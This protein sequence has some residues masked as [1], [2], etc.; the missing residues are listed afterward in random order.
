MRNTGLLS[1][2]LKLCGLA[3]RLA[4]ATVFFSHPL[5]AAEEAP[6]ELIPNGNFGELDANG[7]IRF[8]S[9]KVNPKSFAEIDGVQALRLPPGTSL[10]W[11]MPGQVVWNTEY[12]LRFRVKS[13]GGERH[14]A[15]CLW[16]RLPDMHE[17]PPGGMINTKDWSTADAK[18][19]SWRETRYK[20]PFGV[21]RFIAFFNGIQPDGP[22]TYFTDFSLK[23]LNDHVVKLD[24]KGPS[25]GS[26]SREQLQ[27]IWYEPGFKWNSQAMGRDVGTALPKPEHV[28]FR[29]TLQFPK[30][31]TNVQAVFCGDDVAKLY[32]NR[33]EVAYT[34][35]ASDIARVSLDRLFQDGANEVSFDVTNRFGPG[36]MLGR[37]EW[38]LGNTKYYFPTNTNWE[39][40]SDDGVTWKTASIAALPTPLPSESRWVYPHMEELTQTYAINVPA[41]VGAIRAT[42]RATGG[43]HFSQEGRNLTP[44]LS[45]VGIPMQLEISDAHA[46]QPLELSLTDMCQPPVG[47]AALEWKIGDHWERHELGEFQEKSGA[48]P[49]V[50]Q[51]AYPSKSWP[52]NVGGFEAAAT[53]PLRDLSQNKED[54]AEKVFSKS[55]ELWSIGFDNR[56]VDEFGEVSKASKTANVP[57]ANLSQFPSGLFGK[58]FPE[59]TL[60][61]HL[62]KA[63]Q[64][65]AVFALNVYDASAIVTTVGVYLNGVYVGSPNV[66]GYSMKPGVRPGNRV[67]L[68]TIAPERFAAGD[69]ELTLRI[70][71]SYYHQ[72]NMARQNQA[73]EYTR[74]M[75]LGSLPPE[76]PASEWLRWDS[77]SLREMNEPI[78]TPINGR[79]AWFGTN[80]GIAVLRNAAIWNDYL[81]RDLGYLGMDY[82]EAPIRWGIWDKGQMRSMLKPLPGQAEGQ[83]GADLVLSEMNEKGMKPHMIL[84]PGRGCANWEDFEKSNEVEAVKRFGQYFDTI[85]TGNEVDHPNYGWDSLSISKAYGNI[86]KATA[87]GQALKKYSPNPRT[88]ILGQGWYFAW[89]FSVLDA[90]QRQAAPNDPGFADILSAHSYG[91]SYII[92]AVAYWNL[93]GPVPPKPIWVTECGAYT[94]SLTDI[95]DFDANLRG[96]LSFA[97]AVLEYRVHSSGMDVSGAHE[98]SFCLFEGESPEA[99]LLEKGRCYRRLIATYGLHGTPLPWK[100]SQPAEIVG[101]QVFVNAVD[102]GKAYKIMFAN[103]EHTPVHLALKVQLP[104]PGTFEA[105]RY[106]DGETVDQGSKSVHLQA[107]PQLDF[108]ETLATGETVEYLIPKP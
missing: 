93:Y 60:R 31:A 53:R 2:F 91:K 73:E 57:V 34:E 45:S 39:C 78:A 4:L 64:Y 80:I 66:L 106:G 97:T 103:Y 9:G 59:E 65:G 15:I 92:P 19:W 87:C 71:D 44:E 3:T 13:E 94:Q 107:R 8:W 32:V 96:N 55:K 25:Y 41:G 23:P 28:L 76:L 82:I 49:T 72:V 77:L 38:T 68:V 27:W 26:A 30:G 1:P 69:N 70:E 12:V 20:M 58:L 56:S 83:C 102:A 33:R 89:D 99:K 48:K 42:V 7:K 18:D 16:N 14:Q 37:I 84:E 105:M 52:I 67:Y 6:G 74:N 95:Y 24:P 108:D 5:P 51:A 90:A 47:Q 50:V 54:W 11:E 21:T 35:G 46:G 98:R 10:N 104:K 75:G 81:K 85:E 88:K 63:P 17:P 61:F 43:F 79:P 22:A 101:K 86:M 100:A 62:D 29:R 40:S 36:G